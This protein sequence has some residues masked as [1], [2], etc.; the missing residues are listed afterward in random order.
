[1]SN[2]R[3]N[4]A[5]SRCVVDGN[6]TENYKLR[7][8][9]LIYGKGSWFII[10]C[11]ETPNLNC[12]YTG[13]LQMFFRIFVCTSGQN[14]LYCITMNGSASSLYHVKFLRSG[15]EVQGVLF[16]VKKIV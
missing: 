1:M 8:D 9:R 15:K 2:K 4:R 6:E 5:A 11:Q 7:L 16:K 10:R 12:L 3:I 14:N 13:S